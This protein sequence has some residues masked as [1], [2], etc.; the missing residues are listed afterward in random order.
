MGSVWIAEHLTLQIELVVKFFVGDAAVH[1]DISARFQR[2]AALAMRARSPHVVQI[3]DHG[4]TSAGT[5]YIAMELLQG[6]DLATRLERERQVSPA[7]FSDWL[8]QAAEGLGSAHAVGVVHRDIKPSNLFLCHNGGDIVVKVLDFGIAKNAAREI[9]RG[10]GDTVTGALL[11]TLA[12]MSP[13]QIKAARDVDF[14]TDLWALGVVTYQALTGERPFRGDAVTALAAAA[15]GTFEL[16]TQGHPELPSALDGWMATALAVDPARRFSSAREMASAFAVAISAAR[17]P[18][19]PRSFERTGFVVGSV[20]TVV[21]LA[22]LGAHSL[23]KDERRAVSAQASAAASQPDA[24]LAQPASSASA[25]AALA[26]V[27]AEPA[28][29]TSSARSSSEQSLACVRSKARKTKTE[30]R[31]VSPARGRIVSLPSQ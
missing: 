29:S 18:H 15:A 20:I 28:G 13:E 3:F 19:Q 17:V 23:S 5:P 11:G 8:T 6:E 25:S 4:E 21:A 7:V 26:V 10:A 24:P 30:L 1:P 27:S 2:E 22:V 9:A 16:V 12:Y 31:Q 14:R